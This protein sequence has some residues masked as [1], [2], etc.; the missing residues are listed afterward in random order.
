MRSETK[1]TEKGV[2]T[3][4]PPVVAVMGHIDHGKSS[5]L[6]YIRKTNVVGGEAGGITQ[7]LGAYEVTHTGKD[8]VVHEITFLDTPGHEAFRGIRERGVGVAEIAILVV[9]GEDGVKPQTLE[10]LEFIK[11][12]SIP[13]IVAI[14]K[15]DKPTADVECAK[16]SLAE[17]T[18]YVEGYGGDVPI[19]ALSN[20]TGEGISDLLDMIVLVAEMNTIGKKEGTGTKGYI[21]ESNVERTKGISATL[22]MKEGVLRKGMFVVAEGAYAPV[23][24]LENCL[25]KEIEEAYPGM[26]V[27]IIGW[28]SVPR[29]GSTITLVE[30]KR[31]AEVHTTEILER[32]K[33]KAKRGKTPIAGDSQEKA[34]LPLI[35]K[36]DAGG[37][38]EAVEQEVMKRSTESVLVKVI[39]R[40]IG[41]I[42]ESDLKTAAGSAGAVV[43]GFNVDFDGPAKSIVLRGGLETGTFDVIYKLLEWLEGI[44]KARTPKVLSEEMTGSARVLKIFNTEKD[45]QIIGGKVLEGTLSGGDEFN[46]LRRDVSI[47]R[48]RIREIQKFKEKVSSIGKDSEFGAFV[49]SS[50]EIMPNDRLEAFKIVEK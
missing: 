34:I 22:I 15:I 3:S 27:R 9:S 39:Q 10:A 14:T 8:G 45:K 5:L 35:I 7:H 42:N 30:N 46:V 23:R 19:V 33:T 20:K 44:I 6:D 26:P 2:P 32:A 36:A 37:S 24:R 48:G 40:G 21:I 38:L 29:S 17:H 43:V 28:N 4:R 50:I 12:A 47:G 31:A 18:I 13:Y 11:K 25:G 1:K 41:A 16:Q 49:G